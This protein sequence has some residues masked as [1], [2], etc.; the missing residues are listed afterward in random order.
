M[1]RPLHGSAFPGRDPSA[2]IELICLVEV[3]NELED[4]RGV[5]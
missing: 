2:L 5:I 3:L 4:S 1:E